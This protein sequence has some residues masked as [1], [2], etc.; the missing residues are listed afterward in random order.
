MTEGALRTLHGLTPSAKYEQ[1]HAAVQ[2]KH[3]KTEDHLKLSGQ[4]CGVKEWQ[5]V[6]LD[7]TGLI[8]R[9]SARFPEPLLQG[10]QRADPAGEFNEGSPTRR[11]KVEPY[12]PPPYQNQ[13]PAEQD[14]KN[15]R[16]MEKNKKVGQPVIERRRHSP[17]PTNVESQRKREG[18]AIQNSNVKPA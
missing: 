4:P 10:R 12:H 5:D 3:E 17:S 2:E 11:G 1:V 9:F 7:E 16:E 8:S 13:E 14:K 15:E 6:V 18:L